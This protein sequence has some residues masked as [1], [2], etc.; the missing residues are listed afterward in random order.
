MGMGSDIGGS[1]GSG[2]DESGQQLGCAH[3]P[4]QSQVPVPRV[5]VHVPQARPTHHWQIVRRQDHSR[6]GAGALCELCVLCE[7]ALRSSKG[8]SSLR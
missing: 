1:G 4:G 3:R 7:G 2:D 5:E 8:P 6:E